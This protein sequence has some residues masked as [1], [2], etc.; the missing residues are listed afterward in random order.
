ME[1]FFLENLLKNNLKKKRNNLK[2]I[3]K[4]IRIT[5]VIFNEN[6]NFYN[7]WTLRLMNFENYLRRH[8]LKIFNQRNHYWFTKLPNNFANP[9]TKIL[10]HSLDEMSP[11]VLKIRMLVILLCLDP[12]FL[13]SFFF[14]MNCDP[15]SIINGSL[16]QGIFPFKSRV[17]E[18]S[19]VI[20][21]SLL[22]Q[23]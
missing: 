13:S 5:Q 2:I 8:I 11:N 7:H 18:I 10:F 3:L 19:S 21:G 14:S 23:R 12:P 20:R 6:L 4:I 1:Y 17:A 22:V 9:V 15:A 16:T